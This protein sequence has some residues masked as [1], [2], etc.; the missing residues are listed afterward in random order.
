M[1]T[2]LLDEFL[3]SFGDFAAN[4]PPEQ[5]YNTRDQ[6][7]I[8][9]LDEM[10]HAILKAGM[11]EDIKGKLNWIG[12]ELHRLVPELPKSLKG[13]VK[14]DTPYWLKYLDDCYK[15]YGYTTDT[16]AYADDVIDVE[17]I[18]SNSNSFDRYK[19]LKSLNEAFKKYDEA[20]DEKEIQQCSNANINK[21]ICPAARETFYRLLA[22]ERAKHYNVPEEE[23][24]TFIR[25]YMS[26]KRAK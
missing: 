10:L 24:S 1:D 11:V 22:E 6:F 13:E 23:R 4:P 12:T 18:K 9:A 21:G 19:Q 17:V 26:G 7:R 8:R 25:D 15:Q 2:H 5:W 20:L 3:D 14:T 16:K